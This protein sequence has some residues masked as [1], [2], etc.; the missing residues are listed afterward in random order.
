VKEQAGTLIGLLVVCAL[1]STEIGDEEMRPT[2]QAKRTKMVNC[3]AQLE[4]LAGWA[5]AFNDRALVDG[6]IS[7][8]ANSAREC[9]R[10]TTH[11][12]RQVAT[13]RVLAHGSFG[14]FTRK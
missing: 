3:L 11:V 5:S 12:R 14:K 2:R 8:S 4:L 7:H 6:A 13:P 1:V 10:S 9:A